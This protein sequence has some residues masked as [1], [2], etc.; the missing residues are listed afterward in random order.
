MQQLQHDSVLVRFIASL[1]FY[2]GFSIA[3]AYNYAAAHP[4]EV[5]AWGRA[6]PRPMMIKA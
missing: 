6:H 3:Q 4:D 5:E 1:F 2:R